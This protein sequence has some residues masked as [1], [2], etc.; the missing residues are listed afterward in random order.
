MSR[1][2]R[3]VVA[4]CLVLAAVVPAVAGAKPVRD[5]V[6]IDDT[7]IRDDFVSE[8]CGFDVFFDGSGHVIF[9][10]FL[11]AEGN[12]VREVNNFGIRVRYFSEFASLRTVDTGVDRITYNED[13]SLTQ[14]IIGNAQS[15]NV[16]GEGR[17]WFSVG[18]EALRITFDEEGDP[19]FEFLFD[20]GQHSD[21]SQVEVLCDLLGP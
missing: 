5:F 2:I 18:I 8:V 1:I 21:V 13:G 16:P 17:V 7:A 6:Q 15:I 10:L 12:P 20:H 3:S 14:L 4:A 19:E 11:D 9:R